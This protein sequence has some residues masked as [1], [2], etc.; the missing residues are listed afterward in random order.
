MHIPRIGQEVIVDFIGGDPDLPVCTG[1]LHNQANLPPWAFPGQSALAG[2][3]SRELTRESGNSAVGRSNHLVLDDTAEKIQAQLKSDHQHSQ[4]SLGHIARIEDN[5]GRKEPRGEGFELRTDGHGV[6]R[7]KDGLL[8]TTE[9]R[10]NAQAHL[11]DM[12]E[13]VARL[14]QGRDLHESLIGQ[15]PTRKPGRQCPR[16]HREEVQYEDSWLSNSQK[17]L[18]SQ[19]RIFTRS[20]RRL[21]NT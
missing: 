15:R 17:P 8:V 18:R 13:T 2:F 19:P 1:R 5:A 3:R 12:G 21:L 6:L 4:L 14:T 20:R 9:G 7:A 11:T 10:P 16:L